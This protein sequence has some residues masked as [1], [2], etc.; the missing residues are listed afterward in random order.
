MEGPTN[1]STS[2]FDVRL[3]GC[4]V[5]RRTLVICGQGSKNLDSHA[6]NDLGFAASFLLPLTATPPPLLCCFRR[7]LLYTLL[8][9]SLLRCKVLTVTTG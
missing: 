3:Q 5:G 1:P 6:V 7:L 9:L 2:D 8:P 4:R